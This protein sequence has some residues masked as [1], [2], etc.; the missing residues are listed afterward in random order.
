[1]TTRSLDRVPSG[2]SA[3][4]LSALPDSIPKNMITQK[5]NPPA[6]LLRQE[7]ARFFTPNYQARTKGI[8][9]V[10]DKMSGAF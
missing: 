2:L 10:D 4:E 3:D 7:R 5:T 9:T 6:N 1:M 8:G